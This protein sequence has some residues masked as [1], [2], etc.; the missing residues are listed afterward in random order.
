[1]I[2]AASASEAHTKAAAFCNKKSLDF[3]AVFLDGKAFGDDEMVI[4]VGVTLSGEKVILGLV[5]TASEN[6]AVCREF[7]GADSGKIG[8]PGVDRAN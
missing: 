7:R 4:A 8:L 5:Q 1:M 2:K 3:V 6:E